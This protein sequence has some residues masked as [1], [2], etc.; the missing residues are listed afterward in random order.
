[1][2]AAYRKWQAAEDEAF[3]ACTQIL[4]MGW[5]RECSPVAGRTEHDVQRRL[6]PVLRDK[7]D[8]LREQYAVG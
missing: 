2:D 5:A 3:R 8:V 4:G 6:V 7:A 1:M